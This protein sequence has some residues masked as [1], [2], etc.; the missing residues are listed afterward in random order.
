MSAVSPLMHAALLAAG[1][2]LL[3]V[4]ATPALAESLWL[5]PTAQGARLRAGPPDQPALALPPLQAL[6]APGADATHVLGPDGLIAR[7]N[8][9]AGDLRLTA[10]ETEG[11]RVLVH[12]QAR[13]GRKETLPVNDLELVPTEPEGRRFRLMWKGRPVAAT[14]VEVQTDAGWQ[15]LLLPEADGLVTLSTPFPG[16]YVLSVTASVDG[17]KV[18]FEGRDYSEVRHS[19]TLSFEVTSP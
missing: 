1:A 14:Q 16:L 10:V 2:G 5:Q 4:A 17:G 15:R 6:A 9:A 19:A 13:L 11:Q 8:A 3:S 18:R 7:G 12:H